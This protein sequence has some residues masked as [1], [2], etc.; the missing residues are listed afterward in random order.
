MT[1]YQL[2]SDAKV[3]AIYLAKNL[4]TEKDITVTFDYA[5]Y[6]TDVSGSEG[7][8]VFF[9]NSFGRFLTGGGPG[10]GLCYTP[11]FGI[12][13][14][15]DGQNDD[16]FYGVRYG[17]LE[18]GFDITGNHG[19]S[20]YGVSGLG[21]GIPNS[22]TLRGS[23]N[24][25]Y[26]RLLT[27]DNL[28]T[29]SFF[30]PL[31]LYQQVTSTNDIKFNTIRIR[32]TEFCKKIIID[33]KLDGGDGFYNYVNTALPEAWP[34]S[35]NCCLGFS[36]GIN[37][38]CFTVKNFN[39]NGFFIDNNTYASIATSISGSGLF[40]WIYYTP[41]YLGAS[42]N[43]F[44]LTVDNSIS[45]ENEPPWNSY[46]PLILINPLGQGPLQSEDSYIVIQNL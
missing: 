11:T 37:K 3:G 40:Q 6:G 9:Y 41:S 4:N 42:S 15:S 44:I 31:S 18:V 33:C 45:I 16:F 1:L 28:T 38:T 22:I 29:S 20:G 2:P 39:V 7:F 8:S 21:I 27:T 26:N 25:Y 19:T 43:P 23:Q 10:P 46:P 5:C 24:I 13:A 35:V 30:Q 34:I 36:S 12:T 32:L 17:Q 14:I